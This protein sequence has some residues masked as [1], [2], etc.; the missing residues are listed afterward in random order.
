MEDSENEEF[1]EYDIFAGEDLDLDQDSFPWILDNID[2]FVSESRGN[3]S[4]T[5]VLFTPCSA[6]GHDDDDEVWNKVGQAVGNLQA[7]EML[8]ICNIMRF[9]DD[10]DDDLD[11][12]DQEVRNP[13]LGGL[14][15][16][17]NHVRQKVGVAIVESVS[18]WALEEVQALAR[19]IHEHPTITSFQDSSSQLTFESL[20]TLYSALATLPALE[21]I[22]LSNGG[23]HTPEDE[24]ALANPGGLTEL[25]R[26]PSLRSVWFHGFHFTRARCQAIKN[27]L[28]EGTAITKL[29]FLSCPFSDEEFAPELAKGLGGNT[30]VTSILVVSK[31]GDALNEVPAFVL[32]LNST[33]QELL[34]DVEPS[35]DDSSGQVDW[36]PT[37]LALG[38]NTGLKTLKVDIHGS[39]AELM[40]TA[41]QS[42]LG[43]NET[44]ES[45]ELSNVR[46]LDGDFALWREALAFLRTNKTLKSLIIKLKNATQECLLVFCAIVAAT[47]QENASLDTLF[48]QDSHVARIEH[49]ILLLSA[50]QHNTTLKRLM[51]DYYDGM[52]HLD[53][54]QDKTMAMLL[55]KN[56]GLESI[57]GI[58]GEG[59]AG[60]ILRLNAAGRRYLIE[61][62]S[63]VSKGVEVLSAVRDDINCVFFHLLENPRLCDRSAVE[64]PSDPTE[65]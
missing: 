50:F 47:L 17:C 28:M 7:L 21:T 5:D 38:R 56:Y 15:R 54:S 46:L 40:S 23:L 4:V 30:S 20:D 1:E 60:A 3:K 6:H 37:F 31:V 24:S 26:V 49:Y 8:H 32:L 64:V 48:L 12:D 27:A 36:S 35:D 39:M 18:R 41:M 62:G 65:D 45:L 9:Y 14:A 55:R 22:T 33:L 44:L 43:L 52:L 59:D 34:F 42:G 2:Y 61:D 29:V 63:S 51:F 25:L 58:G 53:D 19:A 10:D 13:D 11:Y 16:I 57:S